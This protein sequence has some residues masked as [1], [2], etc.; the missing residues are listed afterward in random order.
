M[1]AARTG[2][3]SSASSGLPDITGVASAAGI[4]KSEFCKTVLPA[5]ICPRELHLMVKIFCDVCGV[6]AVDEADA[7]CA[8]IGSISKCP[9]CGA[10]VDNPWRT[11]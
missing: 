3:N 10:T 9:E 11:S 1:R 7:E 5:F 6:C 2:W 8:D 4:T